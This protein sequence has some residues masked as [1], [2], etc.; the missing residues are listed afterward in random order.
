MVAIGGGTGLSTL[1]KG[2]KHHV[3]QPGLESEET[4]TG[5]AYISDLSAVVTVTDDGGSSGRLRK[6][7]NI[8]PPG[9]IRN[10]IVALSEDETLLSRLF[11]YRFPGGGGLEGHNFGNLFVAALTA[12]TGDFAEAVKLSAE[13]LATR[14]RIFPATTSDVQ[15]DGWM[16]DGSRV[17]GETNITA[18]KQR[19]AQLRLVPANARPLPQTLEAI[20]H[21]DVITIGPGSLF[22]SLIPNVLVRGVSEAIASSPATRIFISN[23]MTQAN[24]S[25]GLSAADH[26]QAI[27]VHAR[28]RLFHYALLNRTPVSAGLKAKYALEGA[29][30]IFCDVDVIQALGVQPVCGDY[31]EEYGGVARHAA[32]RVAR[33]VLALGLGLPTD[34]SREACFEMQQ[35]SSGDTHQITLSVN[36]SKP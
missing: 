29:S 24:E 14:G 6:E 26:I 20:R 17:R 2:L 34:G 13:V 31:L 3:I 22:T 33:D 8:L 11:Q 18:S 36:A 5:G 16:Q 23:L 15:L 28:H 1:L 4:A 32:E 25:L 27:Y 30:Q 12:V 35:Q 10:C 9:D 19:I 7:F 21:A